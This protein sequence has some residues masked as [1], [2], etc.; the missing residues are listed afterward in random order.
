MSLPV[1]L[2]TSL[3][4][5]QSPSQPRFHPSTRTPPKP[6]AAAIVM[7]LVEEERIDLQEPISTYLPDYRSD[8]GKQRP[9]LCYRLFPF[10]IGV[11]ICHNPAP[12]LG[13]GLTVDI[14]EMM[15]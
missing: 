7:Q 1:K 13:I 5:S 6:F 3:A 10:G 12:G 8:T 4:A 14:D 11:G 15:A 9:R 2:N